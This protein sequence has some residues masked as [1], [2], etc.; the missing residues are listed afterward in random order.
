M[1]E[2]LGG[3]ILDVATNFASFGMLGYDKKTGKIGKGLNVRAADEAL[4]EITG[5]NMQR[6]QMYKAEVRADEEEKRRNQMLAD[7]RKQSE[8]DDRA[9]SSAA[10][11]LRG[12]ASVGVNR[13][14]FRYGDFSPEEDFLGL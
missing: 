8:L 13:Q 9:A 2:D 10:G 4:G 12:G 11:A 1:S 14:N 7:S 6:E 3:D 5:R